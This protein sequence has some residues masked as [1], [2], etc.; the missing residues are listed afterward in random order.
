LIFCSE[1]VQ[2]GGAAATSKDKALRKL[3]DDA[4]RDQ[5]GWR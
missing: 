4:G 2:P 5:A 1:P 3:K